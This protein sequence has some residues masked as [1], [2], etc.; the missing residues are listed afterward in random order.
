MK[1]TTIGWSQH[2]VTALRRY[3]QPGPRAGQAGLQPAWRLGRQAATLGL[4][5]LE[6]ARIHEQSLRTLASAANGAGLVKRAGMFFAGALAPILETPRVMRQNEVKLNRLNITLGRRTAALAVAN[7]KL[8]R[9]IVC[10]QEVEA[11]LK[12]SANNY[13]RLLKESRQLQ[14]GLR[15]LTRQVLQ[16][17]EK[18]RLKLS[19]ELRNEIAQTLLGINVRLLTLKQAAR[20]N[21]AGLKNEI[22]SSR[23]LVLKS[24]RSVQRA[25]REIGNA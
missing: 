2:Y 22:A 25:A 5:T 12:L 14:Q 8:Q 9:S 17:R 6:L 7:D 20:R 10:R 18:E 19:R 16:A 1:P 24:T 11:S 23:R 13:A 3:L 21:T 15:W 4:E